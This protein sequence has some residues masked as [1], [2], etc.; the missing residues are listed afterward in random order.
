MR[1]KDFHCKDEFKAYTFL[2]SCEDGTLSSFN[3][4]GEISIRPMNFVRV[5]NYLYFHGA[6]RGEKLEGIAKKACFNCYQS[7]ALI[8][9]Y[10]LHPSDACPATCLYLSVVVKGFLTMEEDIS[11]KA[12][13]LQRMM[14]KL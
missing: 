12:S 3:I 5:N 4:D 13:V 14:E 2:D 9:S 10:W 1:R 7:L 8:P 6:R 11:K